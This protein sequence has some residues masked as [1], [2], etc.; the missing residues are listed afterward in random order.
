MCACS[1][2]LALRSREREGGGRGRRRRRKRKRTRT[3]REG[4]GSRQPLIFEQAERATSGLKFKRFR[5]LFG[6]A[7]ASKVSFEEISAFRSSSLIIAVGPSREE[8]EEDVYLALA[9]V[10]AGLWPRRGDFAMK[11]RSQISFFVGRE[12]VSP[13]LSLLL[14]FLFLRL[15]V[16]LTTSPLLTII[17]DPLSFFLE[18][19]SGPSSN[20]REQ[21][22]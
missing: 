11:V 16:A 14:S 5:R 4:E 13:S 7:R 2:F 6:F 12:D 17:T 22:P 1:F 20:L 10:L 18:L 9:F 8:E 19:V 3:R 21:V 15:A